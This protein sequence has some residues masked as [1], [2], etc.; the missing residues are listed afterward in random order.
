MKK[1]LPLLL[2]VLVLG[3]PAA[4]FWFGLRAERVMEEQ[5]LRV[6]DQYGSRLV[7]QDQSRGVFTST[8]RYVLSLD[9]PPSPDAAQAARPVSLDLTAVVHHGPFPLTAGGLT[10]AL[11]LVDT[12]LSPREGL[13]PAVAALLDALPDLRRTTLRTTFG[14]A[15]DSRTRLSV[16]P[17]K[18]T[19]R[20]ADGATRDIQWQGATGV[21]DVA[22]DA[23]SF[24]LSLAVPLLGLKDKDVAMTWQGLSLTAHSVR[25]GQNLFLGETALSLTAFRLES[26]PPAGPSFALTNLESTAVNGRRNEVVDTTMTVRGT[27]VD[28]K[29]QAKAGFDAAFSLKNLDAAT[30]DATLGE[31][32]RISRQP[33][34]PEARNREVAALLTRQAGPLLSK[35]PRFSVDRLSLTLPSGVVDVSGSV[36]YAGQGPLPVGIP[37]ALARLS[38]SATARAPQATL[39]ELLT[40]AEAANP[41]QAGPAARDRAQAILDDLVRKGF[42]VR[43]ADRLFTVA[44]WDGKALVVNGMSLFRMP[45][46]P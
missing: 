42:A 18:G 35:N 33:G 31:V 6:A 21:F 17:A 34:S 27:G 3:L 22:A 36:A 26:T 25:D 14:F 16:P 37:E 32:R 20:L 40:A 38:A 29:T 30:L 19:V 41:A 23:A 24:E 11:A 1:F 2:L 4:Y 10:P 15:G 8:Y 39:V 45:G 9:P 7:L 5:R 43:E 12:T 28:L 44:D 13:P 46:Q